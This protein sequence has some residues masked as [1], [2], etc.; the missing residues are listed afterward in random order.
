ML[1]YKSHPVP[2]SSKKNKK[3]E[4]FLNSHKRDC[5]YNVHFIIENVLGD[6]FRS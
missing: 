3:Y 6:L 5:T 2:D 4:Y 1:L